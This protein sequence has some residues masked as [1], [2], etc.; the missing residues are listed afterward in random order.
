LEVPSWIE[1]FSGALVGVAAGACDWQADSSP[2]V[3]NKIRIGN[4]FIR[5]VLSSYLNHNW[6]ISIIIIPA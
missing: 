4:G 6:I 2:I 5:I 3:I 1:R